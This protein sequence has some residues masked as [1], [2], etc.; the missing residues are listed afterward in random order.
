MPAPDVW[1]YFDQFGGCFGQACSCVGQLSAIRIQVGIECLV[2]PMSPKFGRVRQVSASSAGV[3]PNLAK[4][5]AEFGRGRSNWDQSSPH[6]FQFERHRPNSARFR[7]HLARIWPHRQFRP[8]AQVGP[9]FYANDDFDQTPASFQRPQMSVRLRRAI[10]RRTGRRVA[11]LSQSVVLSCRSC[12]ALVPLTYRA[13]AAHMPLSCRPC[14][15]HF[16][17]LRGYVQLPPLGRRSG[18][19]RAQRTYRSSAV[20]M[21]CRS[22]AAHVGRGLSMLAPLL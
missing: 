5:W 12:A 9:H 2:G 4:Y 6:F 7:L 18:A 14:P 11:R 1:G 17:P 10:L 13:C 20:C 15:A 21:P 19:V 16:P 8:G 3:G 22:C